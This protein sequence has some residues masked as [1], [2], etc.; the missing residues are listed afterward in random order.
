MF[1]H[2]WTPAEVTS[3]RTSGIG[4]GAVSENW[5]VLRI[6][7]ATDAI[8]LSSFEY[9]VATVSPFDIDMPRL[10]QAA[11]IIAGSARSMGLEVK[12]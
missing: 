12:G 4:S 8:D 6:R 5:N 1:R 7:P 3:E 9:I 2:S 10:D 11:K